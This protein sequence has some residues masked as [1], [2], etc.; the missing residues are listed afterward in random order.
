MD[1]FFLGMDDQNK[2]RRCNIFY[3]YMRPEQDTINSKS[4]RS[5]NLGFHM[6][7]SKGDPVPRFTGGINSLSCLEFLKFD[8][9]KE[10]LIL[11]I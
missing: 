1:L 3:K 10:N 9:Q 7:I 2:G 5:E 6:T 4:S 11:K 8:L